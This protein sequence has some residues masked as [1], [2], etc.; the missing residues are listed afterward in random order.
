MGS[1]LSDAEF[2]RRGR[3]DG[4]LAFTADELRWIF[5]GYTEVELRRMRHEP[6]D[7]RYFGEPFLWAAL[8]LKSR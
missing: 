7:S 2:Y 5:A 6:E 1:E 3:L 4:G 8:F